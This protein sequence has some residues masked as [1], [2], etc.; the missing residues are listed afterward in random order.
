LQYLYTGQLI[1]CGFLMIKFEY[2][3][4]RIYKDP[5]FIIGVFIISVV[6]YIG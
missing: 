2:F 3:D 6:A 4:L 5:Q 1:S